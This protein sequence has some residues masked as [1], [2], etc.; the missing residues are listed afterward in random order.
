MAWRRASSRP[1]VV[2]M[3]WL[4][5]W[6]RAIRTVTVKE[7]RSGSMPALGNCDRDF[8]WPRPSCVGSGR[9]WQRLRRF[10]GVITRQLWQDAPC[11]GFPTGGA[12]D[13]E[14]GG[15]TSYGQPLLRPGDVS[16]G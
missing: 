9:T 8:S 16:C 3:A 4:A 2:M 10:R 6:S 14:S 11:W 1:R 5:A 12:G 15:A 13:G 7:I